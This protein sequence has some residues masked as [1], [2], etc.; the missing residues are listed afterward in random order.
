MVNMRPSATATKS[1][2][3]TI[4]LAWEAVRIPPT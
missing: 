1:G 4:W 2:M 3:M